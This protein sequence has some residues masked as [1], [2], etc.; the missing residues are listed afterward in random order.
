MI[1]S[2]CI[3]CGAKFSRR[4]RGNKYCG[5]SCYWR[6]KIGKSHSHGNKI[7]AAL[8]GVKKSKP[9]I[10]AVAASLSGRKRPELSSE[11]HPGWKGDMAG[12]SSIHDWV[13]RRINRSNICEQCGIDDKKIKQSH[14]TV[15]SYLHLANISGEYK[16]QV[17][18]WIFLCPKCHSA[19][20]SGRDSIRE[21]F[22]KNN[23]TPL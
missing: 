6:S 7:S 18:D 21:T 2:I 8:S 17:D 3:E 15:I 16:R 9:H 20:D 19:L 4:Q 13:K 23:R 10:A 11:K 14:G 12:Y 1:D 5:K 22:V